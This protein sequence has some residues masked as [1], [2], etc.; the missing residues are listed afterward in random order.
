MTTLGLKEVPPCMCVHPRIYIHRT[1]LTRVTLVDDSFGH[2]F[3][4][5]ASA[6]QAKELVESAPAVVKQDVPKDDIEE[7]IKKL[8]GLGAK[9][10]KE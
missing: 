9:V 2:I 5:L 6:V 1:I 3:F 8:E 7:L 10:A 4:E